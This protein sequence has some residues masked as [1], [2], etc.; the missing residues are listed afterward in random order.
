ME[1]DQE[2]TARKWQSLYSSLWSF[3]SKVCALMSVYMGRDQ[4]S[5]IMVLNHLTVRAWNSNQ[6]I[7]V[8]P[9]QRALKGTRKL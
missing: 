4:V 9:T 8:V 1:T 6:V 2:Y 3:H 7:W 5:K